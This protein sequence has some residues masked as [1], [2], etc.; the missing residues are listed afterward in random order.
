MD[1]ITAVANAIIAACALGQEYVKFLQTPVGQIV[2]KTQ[3]ADF[4]EFKNALKSIGDIAEKLVAGV[5]KK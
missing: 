2:A 4:N 1:P 5:P 3:L